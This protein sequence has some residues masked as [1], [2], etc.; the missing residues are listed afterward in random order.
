MVRNVGSFDVVVI[1]NYNF[2]LINANTSFADLDVRA[3]VGEE[4]QQGR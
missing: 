3:L 1:N 2:V 4:H